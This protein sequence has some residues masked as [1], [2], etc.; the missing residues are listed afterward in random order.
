MSAVSQPC[1][2]LSSKLS[3]FDA[4]SPTATP[5]ARAASMILSLKA[6]A[7]VMPSFKNCDQPESNPPDNSS[8]RALEEALIISLRTSLILVHRPF[9]SSKSPMIVSQLSVQPDCTASLVVSIS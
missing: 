3:V 8:L 6:T 9:A 7:S 2:K 4:R 1:F 5:W